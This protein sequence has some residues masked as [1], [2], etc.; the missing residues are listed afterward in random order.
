M[1]AAHDVTEA[2]WSD[3][4]D[5]GSNMWT[6]DDGAPAGRNLRSRSM[7]HGLDSERT[8]TGAREETRELRG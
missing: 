7:D 4:D 8:E 1:T 5:K 2:S 3:V 6:P